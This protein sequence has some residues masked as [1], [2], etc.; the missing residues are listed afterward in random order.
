MPLILSSSVNWEHSHPLRR[1][2]Y[3]SGALTPPLW[4]ALWSG[5]LTPTLWSGKARPRLLEPARLARQL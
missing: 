5:A 4:D 2:P 1:I 3:R